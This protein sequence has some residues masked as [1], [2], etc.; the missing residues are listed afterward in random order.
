M[1]RRL[2]VLLS[3]VLGLCVGLP[4]AC[5]G[6]FGAKGPEPTEKA[7]GS[8]VEKAA[9][10]RELTDRLPNG[11]RVI[12]REHHLGGVAAFRIYISAGSLNEGR[13]TGAGISHLLE[14]VVAGGATPTRT[15][16]QVRDALESIGAQTNAMTSK[17]WVTYFGE[18][19]APQVGPLIDII[20]DF[21][22]NNLI[23]EKAF[24]REFQVVQRELERAQAD[25]DHHLWDLAD[26][27]FFLNHP[28][29]APV[30]G[31]LGDLKQLT[32]DDLTRFYHERVSPDNAVAVA[33]GDF[34]ADVVM[35]RIRKVLGPWQRRMA[36]P[37]TLPAREPQVTPRIAKAEMDVA[38]VRMVVEFPTVQLTHPDLYPLDILAF[39]LGE[40]RASRL[41]ADLRDKRGLVES[42]SCESITPAGYDGGRFSVIFQADPDKAEAARAALLEHLARAASERVSA[43]ELA[44]AKRQ[45]ASEFVF[46]LESCSDIAA[47]MATNELLVG[48]AHFSERY[49]KNIQAVTAADVQRVA[50]EYLKPQTVCVTSI[51]PKP[52]EGN[53]PAVPEV[54]A[55]QRPEVMRLPMKNGVTVLL[56]PVQGHPSVSIQ[57]FMKGG[58]SVED[59]KT[60]G[61]S[62]FMAE[63]LMKG[64]A[65]R[66]A[67][68]IAAL[69]D[70]MGAE[71]GA[72]AGRNTIYLSARCLPEDFQKTFNLA[73]D[74][75][76]H[77]AFPTDEMERMRELVLAD[78]AHMSDSPAGEASLF[79]NRVFF[80]D[81]PYQ[82]PVAG[83]P[84]VVKNLSREALAAWHQK[85]V[86][87]NNLVIAIFGGFDMAKAPQQ[88]AD[89]FGGLAANPRLQF[90]KNAPARPVPSREVYIK[91][92][93]KD[94]AV[95][96]VAYPGMDIYNVRDRFAMD[97]LDTVVSGY[98][99][100]SGWLHED[101]RSRGLVYEVH[102]YSMEGLRP[103]YF[104]AMAVCRPQTVPE[105]VKIIEAD[106]A[107]ATQESFTEA[108][109]QPA[110]A[111]IITAKELGRETIE[112]WAFE[113]AVDEALGLGY[114]FARQEIDEIRKVKTEDV[115]RVA[116]QY[117]KKPVIV[118]LTG[119][120][121]AAEAV[122]KP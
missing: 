20:G 43:D 121:A 48:D 112:G 88:I 18:V 45:K 91:P 64:T 21:V 26:E 51:V 35:T 98:Q 41:V 25:P 5:T 50:A 107:R 2:P 9:G 30:I 58:L 16:D 8:V 15:E 86:A 72:S 49:V 59:D 89:A 24:N 40:G 12:V 6:L 33:V 4:L 82:F 76:L 90:P 42:I 32:H 27:N 97:V 116:R 109:L 78:L 36:L 71:M 17:Q 75:L 68:D 22:A 63:M 103:G 44:R 47:D 120:P 57:M 81:S 85:Y 99:M 93:E 10:D 69:L 83:T 92:T 111:T 39:I 118:I 14:H 80:T 1:K 77:P 28:A 67:A 94:A 84:E 113:A 11:L 65:T 114:G 115:S 53:T 74:C 119:D 46:G 110:R 79:F 13:Y 70:S 55:G 61:T 62:A 100:P 52:G 54:A 105:V 56:C 106:F 38:S 104:T 37:T 31:Y 34:D 122:R 3:L 96:Y 23:E 29:R 7:T 19:A 66:K 108:Q 101:L 117:L 60:A 87:A 95:V 73:A 102:A